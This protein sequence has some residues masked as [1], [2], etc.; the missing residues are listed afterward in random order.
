[1]NM[2]TFTKDDEVLHN[3]VSWNWG[4]FTGTHETAALLF[5]ESVN[6]LSAM[7]FGKLVTG[8]LACNCWV[9]RAAEKL[10]S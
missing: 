8:G 10:R 2:F 3:K 4:R 1:M 7:C 5:V 6:R 9:G